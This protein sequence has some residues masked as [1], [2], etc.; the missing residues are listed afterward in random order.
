MLLGML[1]LICLPWVG[2]YV[3]LNGVRGYVC[4]RLSI[5]SCVVGL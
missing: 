5:V 2:I 1:V 3:V 4:R